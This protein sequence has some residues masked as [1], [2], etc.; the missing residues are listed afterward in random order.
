MKEVFALLKPNFFY[1]TVQMSDFGI[2]GKPGL[3]DKSIF[4]KNL[5][6]ISSSG[7]GHVPIPLMKSI[8]PIREM[9]PI[10]YETS[11]IGCHKYPNR[12][13]AIKYFKNKL[14]DKFFDSDREKDWNIVNSQ[15]R[16]ILSPRGFGRGCFRTFELLQMGYIPIILFDDYKWLP[17]DTPE[18]PWN[19]MAIVGMNSEFDRVYNELM[20]I[21]EE[22]RQ[23]M[24]KKILEYKHYFT[25]EGIMEQI[26]WFMHGQGFLQ[27]TQYYPEI[28]NF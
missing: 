25:Y 6:I 22:K 11:F 24:R 17:Y 2:E 13:E 10:K 12:K 1:I 9:K 8:Q 21:N 15:S 28:N 3:L 14:G 23:M 5:L 26:A 4:P 20:A 19:E 7:K 18:F 27:C 16:A